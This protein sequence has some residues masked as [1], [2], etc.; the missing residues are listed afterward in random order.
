MALV[1]KDLPAHAGDT[2]EFLSLGQEDPLLE[3]LAIHSSILAWRIL[4]TK[5]PDGLQ[6]KGLQRVGMTEATE[7]ILCIRHWVKHLYQHHLILI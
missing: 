6:S 5:K 3:G 1:V 4:W 2:R 7:H